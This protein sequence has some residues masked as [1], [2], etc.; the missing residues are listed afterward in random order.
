MCETLL[1]V[2]LT[3][4]TLDYIV[5]QS[6]YLSIFFSLFFQKNHWKFPALLKESESYE[7]M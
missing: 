4:S 1:T 6:V 5:D 3:S 7:E 2:Q